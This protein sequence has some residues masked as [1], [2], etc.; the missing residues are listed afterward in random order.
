MITTVGLRASHARTR[1]RRC[2]TTAGGARNLPCAAI[3]PPQ[4][5]LSAEAAPPEAPRTTRNDL[6]CGTKA[7]FED[8]HLQAVVGAIV[9]INECTATIDPGSGDGT[10]PARR[11]RVAAPR[12]QPLD[13]AI[14]QEGLR[15]TPTR[16]A[17]TSCSEVTL[18]LNLAPTRLADDR[19]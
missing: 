17:Q 4:P 9:R 5:D 8:K 16:T 3:K 1:R 10:K 14:G 15:P 19:Q 13:W 6:C 12:A 2:A 11:L 7:A 18:D